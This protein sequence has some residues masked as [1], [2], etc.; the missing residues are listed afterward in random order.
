MLVSC[1]LATVQPVGGVLVSLNRHCR[2]AVRC[3]IEDG[4][5]VEEQSDEKDMGM[6]YE[7]RTER[8][9]SMSRLTKA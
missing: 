2:V 6:S 5:K 1:D 8:L 7:T 3:Q 4:K 9:L